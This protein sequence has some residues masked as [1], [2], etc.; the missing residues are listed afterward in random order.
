MVFIV[1]GI[2]VIALAVYLGFRIYH[3][4][5]QKQTAEKNTATLP[6]FSFYT[7]NNTVF[8]NNNLPDSNGKIIFNFF[9]PT[10]EHCQYMA[11]QYVQHQQ[12]LNGITILMIT[13]ADSLAV[14]E[15]Y[16]QYTLNQVP[17]IIMLR[18][19][20]FSFPKIFGTGVV[21]CFFIYNHQKLVKK[22]I[23]ETKME[24]LISSEP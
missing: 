11:T 15:F 22:I 16:K 3:K 12:Q 4:I 20:K 23:G 8:T 9:S 1:I 6:A 14:T 5:Q 2:A 19:K 21:P 17:N 18:D 24:N 10:C 13:V 7:L